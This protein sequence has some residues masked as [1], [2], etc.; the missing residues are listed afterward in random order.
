LWVVGALTVTY[1]F[2]LGVA[3]VQAFCMIDCSALCL[4]WRK[5]VV[6]WS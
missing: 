1:C 6:C 3:V 4:N 5:D 2:R